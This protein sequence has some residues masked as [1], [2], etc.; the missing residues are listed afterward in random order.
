MRGDL[1]Y[2]PDRAETIG[3][4]TITLQDRR[5]WGGNL[6]GFESDSRASIRVEFTT[7]RGGVLE[8]AT[9]TGDL[10]TLLDGTQKA[11]LKQL[12]SEIRTKAEKELL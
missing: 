6:V 9:Q 5:E 8:W 10:E 2:K 7:E 4:I 12:L 3:N 1:L 11:T